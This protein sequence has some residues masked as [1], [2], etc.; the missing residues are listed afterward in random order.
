MKWTF[1]CAIGIVLEQHEVSPKIPTLV[2]TR[3]PSAVHQ[4]DIVSHYNALTKEERLLHQSLTTY[5]YMC[6]N[7][8]VN[9]YDGDN[10][11]R[12]ATTEMNYNWHWHVGTP[13]GT[14]QWMPMRELTIDEP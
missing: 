4:W 14:H 8:T 2:T 12:R 3:T 1:H 6:W 10:P 5:L 9:N 11:P 13:L 7:L